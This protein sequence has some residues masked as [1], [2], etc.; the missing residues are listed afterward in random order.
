MGYSRGGV[1]RVM[2]KYPA[3]SRYRSQILRRQVRKQVPRGSIIMATRVS[4]TLHPF[5]RVIHRVRR[6]RPATAS[7]RKIWRALKKR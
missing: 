4:G 3:M 6:A 5:R 7:R 2:N 1:K